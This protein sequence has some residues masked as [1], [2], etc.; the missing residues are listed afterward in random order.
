MQLDLAIDSASDHNFWCGLTSDIEQGG[1]F[2]ATHQ[3]FRLGTVIELSLSL[4]NVPAPT[5]M[6][7]VV[8]WVRQY[9]EESDAPAGIGIQFGPL[10]NEIRE[11][12][13]RFT[14]TVREPILFEL[15]EPAM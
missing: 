13:Q 5:V 11:R 7:G 14:S 6:S 15:D 3:A 1:L 12:L 10:A 2:V 8:R 9:V 4:P